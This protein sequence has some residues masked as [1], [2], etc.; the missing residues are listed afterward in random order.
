MYIWTSP[1]PT[2]PSAPGPAC[3]EPLVVGLRSEYMPN[4]THLPTQANRSESEICGREGLRKEVIS[5]ES[6]T[7]HQLDTVNPGEEFSLPSMGNLRRK[8]MRSTSSDTITAFDD[9]MV[10]LGQAAGNCKAILARQ[11]KLAQVEKIIHALKA[12]DTQLSRLMCTGTK[13][14]LQDISLQEVIE[15][16]TDSQQDRTRL[17]CQ[18]EL[19]RFGNKTNTSKRA[20]II[21][22]KTYCIEGP[23]LKEAFKKRL[24]LVYRKLDKDIDSLGA[25]FVALSKRKNRLARDQ[26][27]VRIEQERLDQWEQ[28]LCW[29]GERLEGVQDLITGLVDH[30]ENE[31][32]SGS[33]ADVAYENFEEDSRIV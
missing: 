29:K 11:E 31:I 25:D 26:S 20:R 19:L 5:H 15:A 14:R 2:Y 28:G 24:D 30:N 27:R 18:R 33:F 1:S 3:E 22:D 13:T 10:R 4:T 7:A 21:N 8:R 23:R 9:N 17:E 32:C 12:E 16:S 6:S